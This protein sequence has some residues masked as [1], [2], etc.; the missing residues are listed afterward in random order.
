MATPSTETTNN[1]NGVPQSYAVDRALTF[2]A[3]TSIDSYAASAL[4]ETEEWIRTNKWEEDKGE[5][6]KENPGSTLEATAKDTLAKKLSIDK[7]DQLTKK[8]DTNGLGDIPR[9]LLS[10]SS[11]YAFVLLQAVDSVKSD[12]IVGLANAVVLRIDNVP[13]QYFFARILA[14]VTDDLNV[15]VVPN[16]PNKN[17]PRLVEL[18]RK[19]GID[20]RAGQVRSAVVALLNIVY[21][22]GKVPYYVELYARSGA[23]EESSFTPAI[24]QSM[25]DYLLKLG[26][27][28]TSDDDFKNNDEYL[29]LAY[30][31][32]QK[33]SAVADDPIDTARIKGGQVTW[34]F[35]VDNFDA[36]D[37]QGIIP[38]NIKAAGAL[39]YIYFIGEGMRVFDVANA[40][41]L[42]WASGMLDVPEGKTASILYRFHKLRNERSTSA[43]RAMLYKRVLNRGNG[44]LLSS[45]DVWVSRAPLYQATKNL[46]YNLTEHMTGMS[47]V[48]VTEDYA[49]LQEALDII[50]SEDIINHFGGRRKTLWSV[51]E[52]VAKEDLGTTVPTAPLRTIA[53]EGNKIFQWIASFESE[54]GVREVDFDML[55]SAAESWIISQASMESARNNSEFHD[56][57]SN[58]GRSH[59]NSHRLAATKPKKRSS[60]DD[61]DDWDV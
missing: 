2:R 48:Q 19:Q 32:A 55:L 50:R 30:N 23:V 26:V 56:R 53:V 49:H 41:V 14:N 6:I 43:E 42:R 21:K 40:L 5:Y 47:H 33:M 25:I 60:N 11:I 12:D 51:I 28:F 44:K 17:W 58:N 29:A 1:S 34:N 35:V 57:N 38:E 46:Q 54:G 24:K 15:Q 31:E 7:I 13:K 39:D 52:R 22:E 3:P 20:I 8:L 16:D 36:V 18:T 59:K 45:M 4:K 37:R 61:F 9:L 10:S 27:K